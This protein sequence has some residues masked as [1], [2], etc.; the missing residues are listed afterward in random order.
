[1]HKVSACIVS[2]NG[3]DEVIRAVESLLEHTTGC[4]LTLYLVDNA[5]P[6]GTAKAL[7]QAGFGVNV[8]VIAL[9]KNLG[10]GRGHNQVLPLINSEYHFVLNPDILIKQDT[11]TEMCLWLDDHP[12][13]VMATPRLLF[14][15]SGQ[16]QILPKRK[17]SVLGLLARQGV[18]GLKKY[19]DHYAMLDEDLSRPIPVEFCTGSF[20][21]MRS[22]VFKEIGGFDE[23]Y[24]MYVED[25][26]ITQKA[27]QQG[28]CYFLPQI[29]A[30]HA[31]HRA[32][33]KQL[34]PF[35]MQLKSMGRYFFK[36]GIRLK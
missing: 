1:M 7:K 10:F 35:F 23:G 12:E 21:C 2:Y 36:W 34:K 19:G 6:D 22:E 14:P 31:W 11:L 28:L 26:D 24:F 8:Q 13:A 32:P 15:D 27:R 29:T 30:Y 4:E 3:A 5:S 18:P 16:E 33:A 25:A 20:F 9:Q 17:P